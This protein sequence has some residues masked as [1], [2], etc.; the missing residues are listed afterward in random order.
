MS[1]LASEV[2]PKIKYRGRWGVKIAHESTTP[3]LGYFVDEREAAEAY[4]ATARKLHGEIWV[5]LNFPSEWGPQGTTSGRRPRL[6]A[7]RR[8]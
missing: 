6:T 5:G 1:E 3:I 7:V 8:Q 2:L 4:G